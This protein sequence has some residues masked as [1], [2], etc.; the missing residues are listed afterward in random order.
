MAIPDGGLI[1]ETNQQYY[2]GAQ[3]FL[4]TNVLGQSTFT[5][6][7][8]TQLVFGN[9]DPTNVD[10]ALNNFKLYASTDGITY[11]EI[12]PTSPTFAALGP[13]TVTLPESG[14]SI[15][16]LTGGP[17]PQNNVI[18]CQMKTLAGGSFGNRDALWEVAIITRL[19]R[20]PGRWFAS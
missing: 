11:E 12:P 14:G 3:G 15:V 1:T 17:L 8:D 16:T 13:Y 2:A 6:T 4:V 10:Y 9:W 7:F 20:S 18:V 19:P 5:F